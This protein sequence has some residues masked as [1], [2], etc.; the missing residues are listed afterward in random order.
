M[1]QDAK[2]GGSFLQMDF[3]EE[4]QAI[5]HGGGFELDSIGFAS[6]FEEQMG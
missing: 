2:R 4:A 5:Q 6:A 1:M 3:R